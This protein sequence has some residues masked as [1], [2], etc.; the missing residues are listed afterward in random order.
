[1]L[2]YTY[3][4]AVPCVRGPIQYCP[5]K[6]SRPSTP[7]PP[8]LRRAGGERLPT[9]LSE[10]VANSPESGSPPPAWARVLPASARELWPHGAWPRRI[11]L[12]CDASVLSKNG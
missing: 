2:L 1:I 4:A 9:D 8:R 7:A 3:P 6:D 12:S 10:T 5:A 11:H